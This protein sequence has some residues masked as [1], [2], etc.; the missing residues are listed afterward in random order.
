MACHSL[1]QTFLWMILKS[2]LKKVMSNCTLTVTQAKILMEK[3]KS[4]RTKV[5]CKLKELL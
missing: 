3:L 5:T 4:H 2:Y 1:I